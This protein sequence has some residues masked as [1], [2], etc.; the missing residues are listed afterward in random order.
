MKEDQG[1][2]AEAQK[3]K[4]IGQESL[5]VRTGIK[6]GQQVEPEVD[7]SDIIGRNIKRDAP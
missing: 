2:E 6:A 7:Q 4:E 3:S 5:R 1:K